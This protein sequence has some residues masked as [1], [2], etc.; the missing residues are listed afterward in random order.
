MP[1]FDN[2]PKATFKLDLNRNK[3]VPVI[4]SY[5]TEGNC[6][7]LYFRYTYPNGASEKI[8]IDRIEKTMNNSFFGINYYCIVTINDIQMLVVLYHAKED[9]R[10]ALRL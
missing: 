6:K 2:T 9:N 3:Y 1:F 10:W 4:A 7:P 8:A 5:D